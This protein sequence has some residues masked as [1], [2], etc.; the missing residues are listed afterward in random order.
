MVG[1]PVGS[2]YTALM[3]GWLKELRPFRKDLDYFQADYVEK[4][5]IVC[6]CLRFS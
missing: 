2:M 1:I 3:K 6:C 5:P 4:E